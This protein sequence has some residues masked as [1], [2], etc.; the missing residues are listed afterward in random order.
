M[1]DT[2]DFMLDLKLKLQDFQKKMSADTNIP[3]PLLHPEE[4]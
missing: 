2:E 4:P 1:V 3:P